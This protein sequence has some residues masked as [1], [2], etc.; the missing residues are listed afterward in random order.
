MIQIP[1]STGN[2]KRPAAGSSPAAA[3]AHSLP[4]LCFA[5][6]PPGSPVVGSVGSPRN[7]STLGSQYA[8]MGSPK[9]SGDSSEAVRSGPLD[10]FTILIRNSN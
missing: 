9:L 4:S 3:T 8:R 5:M 1:E 6:R 7:Y 10:F 2:R